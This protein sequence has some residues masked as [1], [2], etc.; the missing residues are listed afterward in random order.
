[1][2]YSKY[3]LVFL[4]FLL[5]CVGCTTSVAD[6]NSLPQSSLRTHAILKG[7]A[8]SLNDRFLGA[9][10]EIILSA[11]GKPRKTSREPYPYRIDPSCKGKD[12]AEDYSDEIWFYEFKG[13]FESGWEAYSLYV[14]FKNE[15][16]VRI[17]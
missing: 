11:F 17:R 13:K 14:Y 15:K 4:V 9:D 3:S 2:K 10:K 16:V 1:M 7:Q 6:L 8:G 12:C 5:T